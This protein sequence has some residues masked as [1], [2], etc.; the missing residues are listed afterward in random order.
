[1]LGAVIAAGP[2][3]R[4]GLGLLSSE[5]GRTRLAEAPQP[6]WGRPGARLVEKEGGASAAPVRAAAAMR[7]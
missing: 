7:P 1:M 5:L 3:A 2:L 6:A 4:D